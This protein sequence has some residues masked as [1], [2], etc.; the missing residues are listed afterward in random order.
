MTDEAESEGGAGKRRAKWSDAERDHVQI[1][2]IPHTLSINPQIQP[3][4]TYDIRDTTTQNTEHG[5][6]GPS[7]DGSKAQTTGG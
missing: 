3:H 7:T 2:R 4:N 1:C 5:Q 6:C